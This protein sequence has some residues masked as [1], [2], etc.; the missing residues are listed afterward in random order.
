[1]GDTCICLPLC[2]LPKYGPPVVCLSK[3][4]YL[5][6]A[7]LVAYLPVFGFPGDGKPR[8]GLSGC[9]LPKI[10]L[11]EGGPCGCYEW[12]PPGLLDRWAS[13]ARVQCV[14]GVRRRRRPADG[15]VYTSLGQT[16]AQLPPDTPQKHSAAP[17][18]P[19]VNC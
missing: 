9:G 5:K 15:G 14:G 17:Q 16:A 6:V 7:Y 13:W 11:P 10:S 8:S 18:Q 4:G 12:A 2:G 1:M 19:V 3:M